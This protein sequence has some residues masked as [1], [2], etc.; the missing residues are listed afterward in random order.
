METH[1]YISYYFYM[2][3]NVNLLYIR[4]YRAILFM[5][6]WAVE[7]GKRVLGD[8]GTLK[9]TE[10]VRPGNQKIGNKNCQLSHR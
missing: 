8:M 4:I 3:Q 7:E 6:T 10:K 9:H 2:S 1:F 5:L